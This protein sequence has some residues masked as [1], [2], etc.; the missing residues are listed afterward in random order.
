MDLV[1]GEDGSVDAALGGAPYNTARAAARLGAEVEFVGGLSVDRFGQ[2]LRKQLDDDGVGTR[3]AATTAGPT[4]LAAAEIAEDGSATYRFYFDGTSAPLLDSEAAGAAVASLGAHDICFTGGLG[5]VLEPMATSVIDALGMLDDSTILIVDVNCREAI[6]PDR[7]TYVERVGRAVARADLVKVSD[8]DL[9]YLSPDLDLDAAARAL[10]D[11]GAGSVVVTAGASHT[12]IF[13][14]DAVEVV[15]VPAVAGPIV[16]TI[17]AGDTFGAGLLA[18]WSAADAGREAM[19]VERLVSAVRVGQ[20]AAGIVVTRRGADP[21]Y[22][23]ELDVD[24]P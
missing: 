7:R 3:F 19:S 9:A 11:L 6:I 2:L 21:P 23:S 14:A 1:V 17:G 13:T 15:D 16:D 18:W 10:L 4:T 24:W 5:F 12:T 20:A 8:E 22:K